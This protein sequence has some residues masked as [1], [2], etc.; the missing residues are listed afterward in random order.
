MGQPAS[1]SGLY[2]AWGLLGQ[3]WSDDVFLFSCEFIIYLKRLKFC[4]E[5][6]KI[7]KNKK[8][9]TKFVEPYTTSTAP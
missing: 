6:N 8:Y 4:K 7:N 5:H 3:I 2:I 9:Q 1:R